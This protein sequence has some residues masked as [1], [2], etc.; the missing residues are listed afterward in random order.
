MYLF[1]AYGLGLRAIALL[2]PNS[3][4]VA[5]Q[6]WRFSDLGFCIVAPLI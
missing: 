5:F 6:D 4:C 1:L 3:R 2:L